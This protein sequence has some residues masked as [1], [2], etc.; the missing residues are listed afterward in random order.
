METDANCTIVKVTG[1]EKAVKMDF[2]EVFVRAD[3]M[4]HAMQSA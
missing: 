4:Y 1:F 3:V 2:E